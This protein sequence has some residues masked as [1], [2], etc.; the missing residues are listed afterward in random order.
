MSHLLHLH[1][2]EGGRQEEAKGEDDDESP[3]KRGR[4]DDKEEKGGELV[5]VQSPPASEEDSSD[6]SSSNNGSDDSSSEDSDYFSGEEE[7]MSSK[8]EPHDLMERMQKFQITPQSKEKKKRVKKKK[9]AKKM[10]AKPYLEM[11]CPFIFYRWRDERKNTMLTLEVLMNGPLNDKNCSVE[12]SEKGDGSQ[13]ISVKYHL[14]F[15]WVSEEYFSKCN[16]TDS[17]NGSRRFEARCEAVKGLEDEFGQGRNA[18]LIYEQV[19]EMPFRC[20]NFDKDPV[21]KDTGF[22]FQ[23]WSILKRTNDSAGSFDAN[24]DGMIDTLVIQLVAEEKFQSTKKTRKTPVKQ[25]F[26]AA[27]EDDADEGA[28]PGPSARPRTNE[29]PETHQMHLRGPNREAVSNAMRSPTGI[30][31][32]RVGRNSSQRRR[33]SSRRSNS[34]SSAR[35]RTRPAS[36]ISRSAA[37]EEQEEQQEEEENFDARVGQSFETANGDDDK[38]MGTDGISF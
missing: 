28:S 1:F 37:E 38:T 32:N 31:Y 5:G 26:V 15:S 11:D 13:T 22:W 24:I 21:Y 18:Q 8:K 14:P 4:Y 12:L 30:P 3:A 9:Q 34:R 33:I 6:D 17:W 27:F 20:D 25:V 36:M 16:E 7:V 2:I 29:H 19:F 10:G 23:Q 35:S